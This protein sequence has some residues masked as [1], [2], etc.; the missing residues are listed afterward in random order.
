MKHELLHSI[1]LK[2]TNISVCYCNIVS[3]KVMGIN[4]IDPQTRRLLL[5]LEVLAESHN[6][7]IYGN[8]GLILVQNDKIP[9]NFLGTKHHQHE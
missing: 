4:Q 3:L 5:T 7:D 6:H 1:T 9:M 2:P 8:K